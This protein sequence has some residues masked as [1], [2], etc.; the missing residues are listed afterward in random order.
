[1]TYMVFALWFLLWKSFQHRHHLCHVFI[2]R[3]TLYFYS[4]SFWWIIF[5][6]Q[7]RSLR[8]FCM[9]STHAGNLLPH[10]VIKLIHRKLVMWI[11]FW[12]E[13]H[14][15]RNWIKLLKNVL[16]CNQ[17]MWPIF[18]YFTLVHIYHSLVKLSLTFYRL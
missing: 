13:P 6:N 4:Y 17:A 10:C 1:M 8:S 5:Y 14:V 3:M 11:I 12:Y 9:K 16:V 2:C 18:W 15:S 7:R